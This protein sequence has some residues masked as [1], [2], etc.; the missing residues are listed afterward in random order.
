VRS[1]ASSQQHRYLHDRDMSNVGRCRYLAP[2]MNDSGKPSTSAL[3]KHLLNTLS[4]DSNP[5]T[6]SDIGKRSGT[7]L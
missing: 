4:D 6:H 5:I 7:R 3:T 2:V 1:N